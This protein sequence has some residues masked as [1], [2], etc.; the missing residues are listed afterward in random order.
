VQGG[1][2]SELAADVPTATV[3]LAAAV[4]GASMLKQ[5]NAA[6]EARIR[7]D[8]RSVELMVAPR[9]FADII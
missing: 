1:G 6:A 3:V 7:A 4:E 2:S 5:V 8:F 9:L